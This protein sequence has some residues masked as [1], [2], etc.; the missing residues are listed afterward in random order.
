[1]TKPFF[2]FFNHLGICFFYWPFSQVH[3]FKGKGKPGNHC[4]I[5]NVQVGKRGVKVAESKFR[6]IFPRDSLYTILGHGGWLEKPR[7][8]LICVLRS[9]SLSGTEKVRASSPP[10]DGKG[11][12]FTCSTRPRFHKTKPTLWE[13][14]R[15]PFRVLSNQIGTSKGVFPPH[16][17][18]V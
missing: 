5:W 7:H 15:S 6:C 13:R 11:S 18:V 16:L 8:V 4:C 10:H 9:S 14:N 17:L 1:M 3:C 2:L 12:V